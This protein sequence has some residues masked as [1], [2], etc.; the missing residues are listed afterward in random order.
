M[1]RPHLQNLI[2]FSRSPDK[3][4]MDTSLSGITP[5]AWTTVPP[6]LGPN[7]GPRLSIRRSSY[8]RN[9]CA[10]RWQ[11]SLSRVSNVHCYLMA[12][13]EWQEQK[14][15]P[16]DSISFSLNLSFSLDSSFSL[17]FSFSSSFS[18][19]FSFSLHFSF[20]L[21]LNFRF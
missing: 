2:L 5:E 15:K 12:H 9:G 13:A 3:T 14:I 17:D 1:A 16:K 19:D 20:N 7:V 4:L 6:D 11:I 18:L 10:N 21:G 8:E